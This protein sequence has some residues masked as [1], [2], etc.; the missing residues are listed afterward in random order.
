MYNNLSLLYGHMGLYSTAREYALRAVDMVRDMGARFGLALY[1]DSL[2]RAEMN[3]GDFSAAEAVFKEGQEVAQEI[4]SKDIEG[5][6][7]LK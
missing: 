5:F 3:L 4:G 2:A 1:L 7:L 6:D